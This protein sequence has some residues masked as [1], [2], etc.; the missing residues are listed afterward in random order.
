[1]KLAIRML[2]ATLFVLYFSLAAFWPCAN[3]NPK[4]HEQGCNPF[5]S[6]HTKEERAV[7]HRPPAQ[8]HPPAEG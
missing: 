1:M 5:R 4:D 6:R 8:G 3:N 7:L 2:L